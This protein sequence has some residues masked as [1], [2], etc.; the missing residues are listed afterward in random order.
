MSLF[1]QYFYEIKLTVHVFRVFGKETFS[2][3]KLTSIDCTYRIRETTIECGLLESSYKVLVTRSFHQIANSIV[4]Q[5]R[6]SETWNT[7]L[8]KLYF[9]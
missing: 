1:L 5:V 9:R 3:L 2:A 8:T 4:W 7:S 6:W